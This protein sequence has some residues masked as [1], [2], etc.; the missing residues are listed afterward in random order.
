M[1]T[2]FIIIGVVLLLYLAYRNNF[3]QST[4]ETFNN[5]NDPLAV[6]Y[7]QNQAFCANTW[8]QPNSDEHTATCDCPVFNNYG[9]APLSSMNK[10]KNHPNTIV[11]TY[12]II[13]GTQQPS[14]K[15][16]F[17]R[18]IDCYGKPCTPNYSKQSIASCNC[19]VKEG[20]FLTA[21]STCGPDKNNN[22]PN[23]AEVAEKVQ[24]IATA[25]SII[26]IIGSI[27]KRIINIQ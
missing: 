14:P 24:G 27:P 20:P 18:Y 21:S 8:C 1:Y 10:Y 9:L 7:G 11:S 6:F 16:C 5:N 12:D 25:N 15:M 13:Q 17:G 19:Q 4:Y 23:G 3:Y 26:K 2:I 22:L